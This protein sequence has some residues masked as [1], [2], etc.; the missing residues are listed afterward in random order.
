MMDVSKIKRIIIVRTDR[1]G[2]VVLS[3][4]MVTATRLAFPHA[5]I[6]MMV[7]PETEEIVAQNP[8]LNEVV[9]YDKKLRHRGIF[10]T[11]CFAIHLR[12][13]RFDLALILHSTTR[14]NLISFLAGI[15]R[16]IGYSRGKMDF[17]LTNR[18]EYKK[19]LGK[20]HE[21][22]Y[23]L[24]ILRSIGLKTGHFPLI[25]PVKKTDEKAIDDLLQENGLRQGERFTVIHP[26]ASC[27]SKMWP[28]E[29]FAKL[30]DILIERFKLA[31]VLV[32]GPDQVEMP[33]MQVEATC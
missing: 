23:S 2:D 21:S 6:A 5:Y 11:L 24:D 30:A 28:Q 33:D 3:T 9:V 1:I 10:N 26:G 7:S 18:L 31:V 25:M 14:V 22:E 13:K 32:S 29:D 27:I 17:L 8:N 16:R 4:P 15:P 19:R 20:K 12:G